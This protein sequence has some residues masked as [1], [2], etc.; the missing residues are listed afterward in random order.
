MQL[1]FTLTKDDLYRGKRFNSENCPLA[2]AMNRA[3]I[4]E[5]AGYHARI[6][7]YDITLNAARGRQ[8]HACLP[9]E[10]REFVQLYDYYPIPEISTAHLDRFLKTWTIEFR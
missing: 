9:G 7:Y 8:Y 10:L 6:G 5:H 1:T 3:L 4:P 2:L